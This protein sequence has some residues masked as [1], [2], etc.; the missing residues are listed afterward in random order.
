MTDNSAATLVWWDDSE[1]EN[2]NDPNGSIYIDG[3]ALKSLQVAIG[4]TSD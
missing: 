3:Q 1:W 4:S 2:D